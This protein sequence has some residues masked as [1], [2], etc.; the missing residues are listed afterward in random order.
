[1]GFF[2]Y[3]ENK[4]NKMSILSYQ[5]FLNEQSLN[6]SLREMKFVLSKRFIEIL[7]KINHTISDELLKLHSDLDSS[8]RQTFVDICDD[9]EKE[10][11]ITFIQANKASELLGIEDEEKYNKMDK[12]LL[13]NIEISNPVYKQFRTDIRIGRFINNV[14]GSGKFPDSSRYT[15]EKPNDI[16]SFVRLYKAVSNQDEK[17][18]LMELIKGNDISYWYNCRNYKSR[19]D[20][21]LGGSCMSDV[22]DNFFDIYCDNSNVA[23]LILYTN[24]NKATICARALVWNLI[25]PENRVYMDRIYTNDS[26]DE[27]L[28]IEYAKKQGWLYRSIRGYGNGSVV[29]GSTGNSSDMKLVAQLSSYDYNAYPY[30]DTMLYYNPDSGKI[31]N[32]EAGMRYI[33][34]STYGEY[35]NISDDDYEE[36]YSNYEGSDIYKSEATWCEFGEDWVLTNH[37]IKV[38]NS[39]N[40]YAVPGNPNIVR[41][42]IPGVVD[43]HFEKSR[44]TWSDYLNTWIFNG[45]VAKV[46][47]DYER[48]NQVIDYKKRSGVTFAEVDGENWKIDLVELVNGVWKL[49]TDMKNPVNKPRGWHRKN[50][51]VDDEGNIFRRG[52]FIGNE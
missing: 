18:K 26:S 34:Q 16:E 11:Y 51:F 40:R 38:W 22:D 30:M 42:N 24:D 19:R 12:S 25:V 36:V 44:C 47:T 41:C 49:K 31:S 50:K 6:E 15:T 14:F 23:L 2:I 8:K 43:K 20:G 32:R 37:A 45:S 35:E 3:K 52:K 13:N 39:N 33:L 17:F 1:M 5:K 4:N 27:E 9:K 46:W 28:F 48:N 10:E 7:N 29:D 21:S